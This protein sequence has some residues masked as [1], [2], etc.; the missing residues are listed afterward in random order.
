VVGFVKGIKNKRGSVSTSPVVEIQG[1]QL[2]LSNLD[3]VLYPATGFTKG[4]VI[5]YYAATLKTSP[6]A[7]AYLESR[8]FTGAAA[9]EAIDTFQLGYANRTLGLRL[10]T[11]TEIGKILMT[12]LYPELEWAG[13][14]ATSSCFIHTSI[15]IGWK[16]ERQSQ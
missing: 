4:Q 16:V 7:L 11:N 10:P 8:G 12:W 14:F 3:K 13:L 15:R 9:A 6:D 1:R 2:K 5:D